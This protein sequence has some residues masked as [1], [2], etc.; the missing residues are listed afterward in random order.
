MSKDEF[1]ILQD[2]AAGFV[3]R[4]FAFVVDLG[5]VAVIVAIGG[6]VASLIDAAIERMGLDPPVDMTVIFVWMIPVLVGAYYTMFWSLTGRTVG[7]WLMG[8][9]VI[10][11]D[12]RPPSVSHSI[13]RFLGYGLSAITFWLGYAWVL[14]DDERQ[15]WHD[16]MARTWVV[17]DYA[18]RK[19]GE[20]YDDYRSRVEQSS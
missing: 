2:R 11:T 19:T 13:L 7:K 1:H 20:I 4:L 15:A 17:Y 9:K 18:R 8:L 5:V 6:G 16:H 10:G 3:S 12:G 14:I